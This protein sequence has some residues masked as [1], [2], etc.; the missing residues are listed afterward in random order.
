MFSVFFLVGAGQLYPYV[1]GGERYNK[2]DQLWVQHKS[3]CIIL[4]LKPTLEL[5]APSLDQTTPPFQAV[6]SFL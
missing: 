2:L 4:G 1:H 3:L 5:A 6:Q